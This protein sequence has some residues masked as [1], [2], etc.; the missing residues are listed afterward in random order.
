MESTFVVFNNVHTDTAGFNC[1]SLTSDSSAADF[2]LAAHLTYITHFLGLQLP[3]AVLSF[4]PAAYVKSLNYILKI[5][6]G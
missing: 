5:V 6:V 2:L 4:G 1:K 3:S